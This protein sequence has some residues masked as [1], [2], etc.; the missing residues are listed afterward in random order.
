M[1]R[2][3][4]YDCFFAEVEAFQNGDAS[5][6]SRYRPHVI[7]D[8][9]KQAKATAKCMEYLTEL[10]CPTHKK[11]LP[12]YNLVVLIATFGNTKWEIPLDIRLWLPK[13]HPEYKSKPQ[14]M[15][16]MIQQLKAEAQRR[17]ISLEDVL[18]SCDAANAG[19]CVSISP[20]QRSNALMETANNAGFT[21]VTKVSGNINFY[22]DGKK[23]K[24]KN[25]RDLL[26]FA[27]MKQSSR[28]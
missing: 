4:G 9:T 1:L 13:E 16:A 26:P 22:I 19:L 15:K 14:M 12:C 21:I 25:I 20:H 3:V 10:F 24:A 8:D 23:H 27:Q 11:K 7:G 28:F 2:S 18:F 6:R 17:S 5:N